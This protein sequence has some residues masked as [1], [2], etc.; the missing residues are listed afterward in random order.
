M[1]IPEDNITSWF[2]EQSTLDVS[3]FPIGI[4]DDMAQINLAAFDASD[5]L[6]TTDMLLD[7]THFDL[8]KHSIT[9]AAYK[10]VAASLSDCAAMATKPVAAV[11]SVA[12]NKGFTQSKLK[13][14]HTGIISAAKPFDCQLIGG[15][16]TSW[17]QKFAISVTMLS[18][19]ANCV[20]VKRSTAKSDDLI[21]VTGEL[22]GSIIKKHLEFTPRV[23]E[24]LKITELV[25]INSM[26]DITD[27][28]STDLARICNQSNV[29]ALIEAG[30]IPIAS[31]AQKTVNPLDSALHAGEDFELLFTLEKDEYEK[32]ISAWLLDTPITRIGTITKTREVL[33]NIEGKTKTKPLTPQG[34]DHLS[35]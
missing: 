32:L 30:N 31:D 19:P 15:D 2:K 22:G 5:V 25:K 23:K 28:L 1:S 4:G 17:N 3:K 26:M 18:V 33:I 34:Y 11:V 27:G 21:C 7:G 29:G 6:V 12:L 9:Q 10:A 24:A 20:P 35:K 14:L 13:E 8:T 16:I